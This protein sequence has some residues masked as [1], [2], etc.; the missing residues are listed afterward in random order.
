VAHPVLFVLDHLLPAVASK[1]S[2]PQGVGR[3]GAEAEEWLDENPE[4]PGGDGMTRTIKGRYR[5][6]CDR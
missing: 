4:L 6:D 5:P 2:H 3:S 1:A